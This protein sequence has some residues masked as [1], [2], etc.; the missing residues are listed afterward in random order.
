MIAT[1]KVDVYDTYAYTS[2]G[3]LLH[4]DVLLPSSNGERAADYA[5]EWLQNIG[6]NIDRINQDQCR[7]CHTEA[8]NPEVKKQVKKHG[9]FILQMEGCPCPAI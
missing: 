4:F 1:M 6:I 8:A 9:Y 3:D 5:R 7:F 2:E